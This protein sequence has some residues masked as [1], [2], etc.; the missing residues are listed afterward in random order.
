MFSSPFLFS[1]TY[2]HLLLRKQRL[3][4][5]LRPW[6]S[7]CVSRR[8]FQC[9]WEVR[10]VHMFSIE[11]CTHS[12]ESVHISQL[13][14]HMLK[15]KCAQAQLKACT[16]STESLH[17]HNWKWAHA[18][19][20]VCTCTTESVHMLNWKCAHAQLKVCM[21]KCSVQL[22]NWKCEHNQLETCILGGLAKRKISTI[23]FLPQIAFWFGQREELGI[24]KGNKDT[25]RY[26]ER[27]NIRVC[28]R[29]QCPH[30]L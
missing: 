12:G 7:P 29:H 22:L 17:M 18:H 21:L 4:A 2:N 6:F 10:K 5:C 11:K 27:A 25:E 9:L 26:M 23:F 13:K 14:V 20:K 30:K 16:C 19:L 15:R 8:T 28:A 1:H 3:P 24:T